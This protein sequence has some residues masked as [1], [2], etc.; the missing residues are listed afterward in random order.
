MIHGWYGYIGTT[1]KKSIIALLDLHSPFLCRLATTAG[2]AP[3][4]SAFR[5][6]V[7]DDFFMSPKTVLLPRD[8]ELPPRRADYYRPVFQKQYFNPFYRAVVQMELAPS[9]VSVF[10]SGKRRAF[11]GKPLLFFCRVC[12]GNVL[13]AGNQSVG[14]GE[15][16]GWDFG[17]CRRGFVRLNRNR[18][19]FCLIA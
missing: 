15:D 3:A 19:T 6:A 2:L 8:A 13:V 10:P 14:M 4:T 1:V 7:R 5:V 16:D 12:L 17:V 18:L 11:L 9:L